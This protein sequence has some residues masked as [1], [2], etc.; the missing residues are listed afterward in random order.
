[1]TIIMKIYIL[2][3]SALLLFD[4]CFLVVKNRRNLVAYRT[5]EKLDRKIREEMEV[6]RENGCKRLDKS[7]KSKNILNFGTKIL[8]F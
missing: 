3:C 2:L 4:I 1:M 6:F 7:I 5:N 8:L